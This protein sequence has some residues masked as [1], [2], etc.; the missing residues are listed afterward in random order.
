MV[1]SLSDEQQKNTIDDLEKIYITDKKYRLM[2]FLDDRAIPHNAR[3]SFTIWHLALQNDDYYMNYG[4]FAN[5]LL[6]ESTSKRYMK[7]LSGMELID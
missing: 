5:G 3:E 7:E 4:I 2:A 1:D 6:V